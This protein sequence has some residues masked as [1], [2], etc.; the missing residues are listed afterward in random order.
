MPIDT[1]P[2]HSRMEPLWDRVDRNRFKL[3]AVTFLFIAGSAIGLD[4]VVGAFVG[5]VYLW[6]WLELGRSLFPELLPRLFVWGTGLG[7][8]G[9]TVWAAYVLTRSEKWFLGYLGAGL[10]PKGE[11]LE[12]KYALKD[13]A[14]AGGMPVAPALHVIDTDN[15]NAFVLSHGRRR[16]VVGVTTGLVRRLTHEEQRAVFA[17]LVARVRAGDTMYATGVTALALPVW[18]LRDRLLRK[19]GEDDL[20][21]RP[22]VFRYEQSE[23]ETGL[24]RADS[25]LLV[26]ALLLLP[27]FVFVVITELIAFGSQSSLISRAAKADAEGMLLL[28]DPRAML[29]ALEKCIRANNFV[30]GAGPGFGQLFYCWTGDATDDEDDPEMVRVLRL[31]EVLGVEGMKLPDRA[32]NERLM[33]PPAAPRLEE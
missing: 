8:L 28:K 32:R 19:S 9:G 11:L 20:T 13:M 16:P 18:T 17:T 22:P 23:T 3:I 4:L 7:L 26:L 2:E 25:L 12:T 29:S 5:A 27:A 14:I 10:S 30:P 31:R 15:V 33:A 21:L 1:R 6:S 24:W